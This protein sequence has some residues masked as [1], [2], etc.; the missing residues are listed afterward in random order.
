LTDLKRVSFVAIVGLVLL[1]VSIGW[2]F[3]Y[4]GL[5]KYNTLRSAQPWSSEGYL[6]NSQGPLRDHFRQMTGDPD[7]LKW[8]DYGAMEQRWSNW[9]ARF[10]AHYALNDDQRQRLDQLLN[11]AEKV[12]AS[13]SAVPESAQA[14][15][16]GLASVV[17]YDPVKG[18]LTV[19][20]DTPLR[21]DEAATLY[22]SVPVVKLP[23]GYARANELGEPVRSDDG[24]AVPPDPVDLEFYNAVERLER[25]SA[26]LGFRQR[27]AANL[28]GNPDRVGVIALPDKGFRPEMA[29]GGAAAGAE[30][31]KYG[32][33]QVYKDLLAEYERA[34]QLATADF[35]HEQARLIWQ[36]I[37]AKRAELVGPIRALDAE[38]KRSAM[39]LL[40]PD[41]LARG[42]VPPERTQLW[43]VDM[44]TILGL[45]VLGALLI[46]G[47]GTRLAAVGGA[48]ML[49][50]FYLPVPPWPGVYLPPEASGP[51]HS[52][53]INK[54]LIE[55]FALLAIAALPTGTWFGLDGIIRY[56]IRRGG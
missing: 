32:E 20:G 12:V 54:N 41:Q 51:E 26:R 55:A 30:W 56:V 23:D 49:V 10:T 38:L 34:R 11:G 7:D 46:V 22:A 33:V 1:R 16:S 9:R 40:T 19:Q 44:L 18:Q 45:L 14:A 37:Q 25:E 43:Q 6:K 53:I 47:L 21:P 35:Q 2:Q 52:F 27:L 39:I 28:K 3:F 36:K 31:L 50:M 13:V 24:A 29:V 5:W 17:A 42:A 8:L 4:E 48:V 15:L